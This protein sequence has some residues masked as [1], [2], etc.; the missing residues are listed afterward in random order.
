MSEKP[1]RRK[2]YTTTEAAAILGVSPRTV[3]RLCD[4]GQLDHYWTSP[5]GER[6]IP[7]TA[8]KEYQTRLA[9][10]RKRNT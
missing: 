5:A 2:P 8:L 9:T 7:V 4:R 10:Q 1:I 3:A 6:R